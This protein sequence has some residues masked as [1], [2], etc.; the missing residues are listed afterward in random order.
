MITNKIFNPLRAVILS[1]TLLSGCAGYQ[2]KM[3]GTIGALKTGNVDNAIADLESKNTSKDKDLLYYL[4]KGELLRMKGSY[5]ASRDQWLVADGRVRAWEDQAKSNPS[6]LLGNVGS[7]LVNDTTRVY[8]GR[9]YE[10][11]F[12][13]VRLALD[14]I[15]NG[16]WDNARVEILFHNHAL[17]KHESCR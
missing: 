10:K 2:T 7:V 8:E 14:H 12:L 5:D 15:A 13:N 6:Q 16:N 4:E 1:I 11:V 3:E 9:D 17:H